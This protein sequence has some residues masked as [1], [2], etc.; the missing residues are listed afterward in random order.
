MG[1][2]DALAADLGLETMVR[3]R[4]VTPLC[5]LAALAPVAVTVGA[6]LVAAAEIGGAHPLTVGP[7]RNVAEAIAVGDAATAARLADGGASVTEIAFVRAGLLAPQPILAS[8]LEV[9]VMLDQAPTVDFLLAR[10]AV[11]NEH[12]A[13]LAA[14]V[15]AHAARTRVGEPVQCR[16][17]DALRDVL[18]RP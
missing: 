11:R 15:G 18:E 13:C 9:A 10:G 4:L 5:V 7:P 14:D 2:P 16:K 8:P 12:L 6:A 17:G 3:H 1:A